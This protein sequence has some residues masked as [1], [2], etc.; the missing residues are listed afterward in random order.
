MR[1]GGP[2]VVFVGDGGGVHFCPSEAVVGV[3]ST[4]LGPN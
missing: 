2:F 3:S 4:V 1:E